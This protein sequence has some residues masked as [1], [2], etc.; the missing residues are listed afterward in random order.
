MA[1]VYRIKSD[2]AVI[3]SRCI[4]VSATIANTVATLD[5][6][7]DGDYTGCII[8]SQNMCTTLTRL[9]TDFLTYRSDINSGL[10]ILLAR[11]SR[12]LYDA[13]NVLDI[14]AELSAADS[15]ASLYQWATD[16]FGDDIGYFLD[17]TENPYQQAIDDLNAYRD[18][19][20][21]LQRESNRWHMAIPNPSPNIPI[22][23]PNIRR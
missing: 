2:L 17:M 5:R 10:E 7:D 1:G 3:A 14:I 18:S 11:Y 19:L 20:Q 13:C 12:E 4:Q 22:L 9:R 21:H 23:N 16:F 8:V 15:V 6:F